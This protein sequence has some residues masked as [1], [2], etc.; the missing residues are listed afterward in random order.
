VWCWGSNDKG[1]AGQPAGVS[2]DL[3]KVPGLTGVAR[4]V[5]GGAANSGP[6]VDDGAGRTCA[7]KWDA[8]VW[9]WGANA[10]NLLAQNTSTPTQVG[11]P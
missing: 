8:S 2:A 10:D 9:C 11:L 1:Q 5:V 6:H 3:E 7:I 4:V